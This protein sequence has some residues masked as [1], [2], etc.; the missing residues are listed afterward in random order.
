MKFWILVR[1]GTVKPSRA[2]INNFGVKQLAEEISHNDKNQAKSDVLCNDDLKLIMNWQWPNILR[3]SNEEQLA[4]S[5]YEE[6]RNITQHYKI[7]F[8]EIFNDKLTPNKI[9]FQLTDSQKTNLSFRIFYDVLFGKNSSMNISAPTPPNPD[10]LLRPYDY[11]PPYLKN[12]QTKNNPISEVA[13][14]AK[15]ADYQQM[16]RNVSIRLAL[17]KTLTEDQIDNIWDVCRIEQS[18]NTNNMSVWCLA[19]TKGDVDLL[20]YKEDLKSYYQ[21]G[22]GR[23]INSHIP[24]EL[25]KLLFKFL[26]S[27]NEPNVAAYFSHIDMIQTFL[28]AL[29]IFQNDMKLNAEYSYLKPRQWKTSH[30]FPYAAHIVA[31]KYK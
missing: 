19:F 17:N 3:D 28:V 9:L 12:N 11:C 8:P 7:A 6:I 25:F 5:G 13:K 21:S 24:C 16:L 20:E 27:K 15:S 18:L 26:K 31:I 10:Y 4:P 30:Y 1:H 2:Q 22:P 23:E 29:N 14:F